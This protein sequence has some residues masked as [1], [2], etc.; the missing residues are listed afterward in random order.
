MAEIIIEG[1][2]V[3][4]FERGSGTPIVLLHAGAGSG[5]QWAKTAGLLEP[6]FRVIAPDLWGFGDSESWSAEPELTH[7]HQASPSLRSYS[8]CAKNRCA[9]SVTLTEARLP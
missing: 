1:R 3:F 5:K 7:D 8:I 9:S 6:R 4:Y 2:R